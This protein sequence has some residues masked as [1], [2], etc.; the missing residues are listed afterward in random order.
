LADVFDR[1]IDSHP[2]PVASRLWATQLDA[3]ERLEETWGDVQ[4]YLAQLFDW[5]GMDAVEAEEL[6]V[7]PGLDE[8]FALTEI[9][10]LA[11]DADYD[12][13]V[14][15]CAPTADTLRLLSLP[16]I[17][18]WYMQRLFP[19]ERRVVRLVRP[20]VS[21]LTS[22]PVAGEPVFAG[23]LRLYER[24]EGVRELLADTGTTSV[25]LVVNP[26][27]MVIAEA[28]RTA[29]YLGL[30]GYH[31][32][33]VVANR[34]LPEGVNDPWFKAWKAAHAEHLQTIEDGFAPLPVL[35]AELAAEELV[36]PALLSDFAAAIYDD[37]DPSVLMHG[38]PTMRLEARGRERV[39]GL[40]LPFLDADDLELA[41]SGEDLLVRVGPYR[42]PVALPDSLRRR[43]VAGARISDGWL[44]VTFA[45]EPGK[46]L[47]STEGVR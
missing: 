1:H 45:S 12:V 4:D 28:R 26:E 5:A 24:L 29:T 9:N 34:L 23:A 46:S 16:D 15:D 8:L 10:T 22:M 32:D 3:T 11:R 19:V 6:S 47:R 43:S 36:G 44:E 20:V 37:A 27:K 35:R 42:R 18:S 38:E 2:T 21:R 30:F 33:A 14:V 25:R 17:L 39:L 41:R 31:V 40:R 13:V 7:L